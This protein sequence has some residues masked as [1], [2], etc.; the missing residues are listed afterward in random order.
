MGEGK[1]RTL[2]H[3]KGENGVDILKKFFPEEWV[4]REYIPDYGIDLSVELFT[5]YDTGFIT[6]GEHI[7]FQSCYICQ[8]S[9]HK[10]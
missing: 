4:I 9:T 10:K 6:S 5:P 8:Y 7:F 2:Q 1:K 3:I